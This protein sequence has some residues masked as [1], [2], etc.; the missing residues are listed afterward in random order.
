MTHAARSRVFVDGNNVIGTR[1]DGGGATAPRP[2][3][4]SSPR[5]VRR[6][7]GHGGVW[8]IVFDWNDL[9]AMPPSKC[10][11]VIHTKQGRPGRVDARNL[12]LVHKRSEQEASLVYTSDAKLHT[13]I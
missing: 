2:L 3:E 12:E 5:S 11:T 13:R 9:P 10:L 7:C 6:P 1:P 8:T 4:G